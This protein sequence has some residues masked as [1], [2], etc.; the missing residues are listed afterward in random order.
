[1]HGSKGWGSSSLYQTEYLFNFYYSVISLLNS[2]FGEKSKAKR[3]NKARLSSSLSVWKKTF[4]FKKIT[5]IPESIS[6][7]SYL[8]KLIKCKNQG[9]TSIRGSGGNEGQGRNA[10]Q[11]YILLIFD[12]LGL[13]RNYI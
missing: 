4:A 10:K 5:L 7:E 1:M 9:G 8:M 3:P 11:C 12:L 6:N 13:N 2:I